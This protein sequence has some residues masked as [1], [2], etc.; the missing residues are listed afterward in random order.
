LSLNSSGFARSLWRRLLQLD[1][2]VQ[3]QNQLEFEA[4]VERNLRWNFIFNFLDGIVFWFGINFVSSSAIMPLFVSKLTDNTLL[5]GL[6]AVIAQSSWYLPQIITAGPIEKLARKKPVTVNIGFFTER[7][8]VWL[9]P[10]AALI[11]PVSSAWALFLFLVG[12]AGFGFGAGVVAPAWQDLIASCF[13]VKQRGRFFGITT[14]VGTGIGAVAAIFGGWM[15][16]VYAFPLNFAVVFLIGAIGINISW[17]FQAFVREPAPV[18]IPP[19]R[20]VEQFWPKL[21]RIL[22]RDHNFR[23][24]LQARLWLS[25]G[26]MGLGFVTVAAVQRLQIPDST[27]GFY[28]AALLAGQTSATLF[29]GWLADKF[30]HKLSLELGSL[31]AAVSFGLAWLA[32]PAGWY[33]VIFACLGAAIGS[34]IV[35]GLL[36][37]MEFSAPK[38]RPTY[39]GISNTLFGIGSGIAPILGGLIAAYSYTWLFAA[40]TLFS[41]AGVIFLHWTVREPRWQ[42]ETQKVAE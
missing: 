17:A 34:T 2:P 19:D 23:N 31:F 29:S 26:S 38:E 40:S 5:I 13:P 36:I 28:T 11:A 35:S 30:G 4:E 33:F 39:M 3:P 21:T 27:V 1:R 42:S 6:V 9:W 12:Y 15:L 18:A 25:L 20:E 24:F 41:V 8:P 22:R 14:F 32:P 16:E 10:L 7:V 37:A